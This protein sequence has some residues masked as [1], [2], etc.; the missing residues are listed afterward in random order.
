MRLFTKGGVPPCD[1]RL[2]RRKVAIAA[3]AALFMFAT[4]AAKAGIVDFDIDM[5]KSFMVSSQKWDVS[6]IFG[7]AFGTIYTSTVPQVADTGAGFSSEHAFLDGNL[8]VDMN[9]TTISFPGGSEI[10]FETTGS[11]A[12]FDPIYFDPAHPVTGTT[13]GNFGSTLT[14]PLP[15]GVV[16]SVVHNAKADL[17]NFAP[18]IALSGGPVKT[19]PLAFTLPGGPGAAILFDEGQIASAAAGGVNL[20]S[21]GDIVGDPAA[22]FGNPDGMA[23]TPDGGTWDTGTLTLTLPFTSSFPVPV[24]LSDPGDG[25]PELIIYFISTGVIVATPKVP[26]PS[27]MVL[28]GFGV[29]GLLTCAWRAKTRRASVTS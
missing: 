14:L 9:P 20:S 28:L 27:T 5:T 10:Y 19:F 6:K 15:Y 17:F 22:L 2:D 1:R 12:P 16:S 29:V 11:Y 4:P 26:E 21:E 8:L 25:I 3:I 24:D 23:A 13:P 18:P 7:K